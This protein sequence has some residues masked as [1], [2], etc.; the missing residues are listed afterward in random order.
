MFGA[1]RHTCLRQA[2]SALQH[3]QSVS[4]PQLSALARLLS[5]LAVLE[6]RDGKLNPS[7]LSA[8]AAAQ[9]LGGSII[10]FVAGAGAKTIAEEAA[11]VQGLEKV[12]FV[13]SAA[14]DRGLP[15]NWAPLLVE[16]IKKEGV[17]HVLAGHSAFGKNLLP[18]VAALL[19]VAQI[20]DITGIESEDSAYATLSLYNQVLMI[21]D[22]PL[23]GPSTQATPSSPSNQ[24]IPPR[25][26]QYEAPRSPPQNWKAAPPPSPKASTPRPNVP[27]SG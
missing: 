8:V 10:G 4:A 23:S 5:S 20:S 1:T 21:H 25:S 2:R 19:D 26:S 11:K 16:N 14:Y 15:E 27:P 12:V 13:D 24:Q 3:R 9:K 18:R 17:S 6:Q 7:S 22:Q